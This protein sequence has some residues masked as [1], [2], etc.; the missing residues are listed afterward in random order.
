MFVRSLDIRSLSENRSLSVTSLI[1]ATCQ[2]F[3]RKKGLDINAANVVGEF[4]I[5]DSNQYERAYSV[6]VRHYA[7]NLKRGSAM[8]NVSAS[9]CPIDPGEIP[10]TTKPEV[11]VLMTARASIKECAE[12]L[13][14]LAATEALANNL[15]CQIISL[16]SFISNHSPSINLSSIYLACLFL[17]E[18]IHGTQLNCRE[19]VMI[20]DKNVEDLQAGVEELWPVSEIGLYKY[21]H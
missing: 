18:I 3:R 1:A 19:F 14:T 12:M 13:D 11:N 10:G 5:W 16:L 6:T 2:V 4:E 21:C 7:I 20:T 9:W 8:D 17:A 15:Y